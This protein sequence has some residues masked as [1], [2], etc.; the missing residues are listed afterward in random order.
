MHVLGLATVGL[1]MD[2][3]LEQRFVHLLAASMG[4]RQQRL[5]AQDMPLSNCSHKLLMRCAL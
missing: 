5:H 3:T 1:P 4:R 2:C